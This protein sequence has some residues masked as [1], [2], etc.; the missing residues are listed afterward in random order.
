MERFTCRQNC[1]IILAVIWE[2]GETFG[3]QKAYSNFNQTGFE[4]DG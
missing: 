2:G 4:S 1:D 3:N